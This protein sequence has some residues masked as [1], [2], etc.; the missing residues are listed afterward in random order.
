MALLDLLGRRTSLRILWELRDDPLSFRA[1][2]EAAETNPAVLNTRLAE[3]RETQIVEMGPDGYALTTSG[4]KL[5]ELLSPL[6][7]WADRWARRTVLRSSSLSKGL[8]K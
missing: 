2:T 8:V 7:K 6:S 4:R 1:L 3:L 5:L